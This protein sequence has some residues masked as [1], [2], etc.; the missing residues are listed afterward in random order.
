MVLPLSALGAALLLAPA[1]QT[2]QQPRPAAAADSARGAISVTLGAGGVSVEASKRRPRTPRRVPV[3]PEH[4]A[5]AFADPSAQTLLARVRAAR[6]A[7]DS[8]L[9]AY[10]AKTYSRVSMGLAFRRLGRDRLFMR[11]ESAARV[12]WRR[13]AGASIDITGARGVLPAVGDLMDA[14]D[15]EDLVRES[16][17]LAEVPYFPGG[18]T[19]WLGDGEMIKADVDE[20][21]FVHPLASGAEAYYRYATGDSVRIHLPDGKVIRLREL[22]VRPRAPRWNLV[23]GSF[24]FDAETAQ[25]VRAVYR[26][27]VQLDVW[28][29]AKEVSD[30]SAHADPKKEVPAWAQ[31][32]VSPMR[33]TVGAITIEYSLHD[34]RWWLP[35]SRAVDVTAEVSFM[36]V[37]FTLEQRFDYLSVFPAAGLPAAPD[38]LL[39]ELAAVHDG[40]HADTASADSAAHGAAL[41]DAD[42][43]RSDSAR[44]AA[45]RARRAKRASEC[46]QTG[47]YTERRSEY[48]GALRILVRVPCDTARLAHSADLPPS[49]FDAAEETFGAK[50]REELVRQALSYTAQAG[51]AP[52]R[53]R[54]R[55]GLGDGLLRYNRVEGLSPGVAADVSFGAGYTA[56]A[57]ARIGTADLQP[58]G[59]LAIAR[60]NGRSELRLGV[61]RRLEAANDWGSPLGFGSSL[62]ALL[63][64]DDE[65]F[66]YRTWGGE[67]AGADLLGSGLAWRLFA[68]QQSDAKLE[69][70]FSL[71][72]AFG[73]HRFPNNI[74]ASDGNVAGLGVRRTDSFGLD[75][76]GF[77]LLTDLRAERAVGAFDYSRA[78]LDLT[79]SHGLGRWL[80]GAVTAG[81]GTSGGRVPSQRLW[82]IGG[83]RTVR[84]ERAGTAAGDAY[85]LGRLELGGSVVGARPVLF[86]DAGWAGSRR[87]WSR[88]G[89]PLS[90]AGAGVSFLD[91]LIRLDVARG[92]APERRWTSYLYVEASF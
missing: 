61:Y 51:W 79:L 24:W 1:L 9:G 12:H 38:S 54:I 29:V 45:R 32:L 68:E 49:I 67:L 20:R 48:D 36:R 56:R 25:P 91:G 83:A 10:D 60:S 8:S 64:G 88:P 50:E 69:T 70:Q 84:G 46:A 37:P 53:P 92:I 23:V 47:G 87:D 90:G 33:A 78:A 72:H 7:V 26:P 13:G 63:F 85:W 52:Q 82:Y 31:A 14:E 15:K 27:S 6:L 41:A 16:T 34:E 89:R 5:T 21:G 58:N 71:A 73:H 2:A 19:L 59:E 17:D 75:P 39:V 57:L 80:D 62:R 77:R 55:Y 66:Y 44:A 40:A 81:A 43:A 30:D 76:H 18:E 4:L 35:K 42:S 86:Y 3:T 74:D 28:A 11:M 65:G 22:V